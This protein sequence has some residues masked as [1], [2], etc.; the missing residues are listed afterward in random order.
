MLR[1]LLLSLSFFNCRFDRELAC[2]AAPRTPLVTLRPLVLGG[3]QE[4]IIE[5]ED[6]VAVGCGTVLVAL[7]LVRAAKANKSVSSTILGSMV[8]LL[9]L[10]F[11]LKI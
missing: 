1:P 5:L 10:L 8:M 11:L 6:C 9:L 3:L 2:T 7:P 4:A